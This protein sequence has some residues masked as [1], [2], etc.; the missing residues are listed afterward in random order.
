MSVVSIGRLI[1]VGTVHVQ[2]SSV[3]NVKRIIFETKPSI[4][5]VELCEDRY[6]LLKTRVEKSP[7]PT[8]RFGIIPWL[9]AVL[10]R[11]AGEKTGVFPGAEMVEAAAA[12]VRLGAGVEFI[13]MPIQK[14]IQRIQTIPFREKSRVVLDSIL[15]LVTILVGVKVEKNIPES[16]DKLVLKFKDRYPSLHRCLVEER[17]RYIVQRLASILAST[18]GTIVAVVGLGHLND[19]AKE[20]S[21]VKTPEPYYSL[22]LK[23]SIPRFDCSP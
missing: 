21:M 8:F 15:A 12:A 5:A 16:P 14:I 4:V 19:L 1:M 3:E 18:A 13:D 20:L 23:W 10:E 11:T 17:N 2:K 7:V 6:Y 22:S 9:L